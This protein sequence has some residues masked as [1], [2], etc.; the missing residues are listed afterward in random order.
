MCAEYST[1]CEKIKQGEKIKNT[2]IDD[3]IKQYEEEYC[4]FSDMDWVKSV[5]L[6]IVRTMED[7]QIRC[8]L[9]VLAQNVSDNTA[10]NK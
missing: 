6:R 8:L 10:T 9:Y 2:D 1:V 7:S 5:S 4:D 3:L